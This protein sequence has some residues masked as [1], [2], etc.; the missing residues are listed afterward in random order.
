MEERLAARKTTS[1]S[2][3]ATKRTREIDI[4]ATFYSNLILTRLVSGRKVD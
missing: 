1:G 4:P 3:V 2:D